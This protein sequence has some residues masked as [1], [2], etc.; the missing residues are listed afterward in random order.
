V[1]SLLIIDPQNDFHAQNESPPRGSL[2]VPGADDDA[3]RIAQMIRD[4][5]SKIHSIFI[6]L[7]SHLRGHIAHGKCWVDKDGN[8][9]GPFTFIQ[10]RDVWQEQKDPLSGVPTGRGVGVWAPAYRTGDRKGT[11]HEDGSWTP[12]GNDDDEW[13]E[14]SKWCLDYT[15]SLEKQGNEVLTI[16]P[17]HCII[18]TTG[19][20][21]VRP[22]HEALQEWTM[23][24]KKPVTYVA[25]GMNCRVE[26]YSALRADVEDPRD[27][28]TALNEDLLSVLKLADK[29][30]D[31]L[32]VDHNQLL[33]SPLGVALAGCS[34]LCVARHSLT[35]LSTP[36]TTSS[37]SGTRRKVAS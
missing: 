22:I 14:Q 37:R 26:S 34:W 15:R 19:H 21:V 31:Q 6:T 8:H 36:S 10:H 7:D 5:A 27:A 25:K 1:Y 20:A 32:T 4:N 9:P 3:K 17:E 16:W 33:L 35:A 24:T 11:V 29:V 23:K 2:A 28:T 30:S 13:R 12:S 18:G